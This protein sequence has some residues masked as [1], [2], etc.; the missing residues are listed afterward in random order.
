MLLCFVLCFVWRFAQHQ[1]EAAAAAGRS[2]RWGGPA[3]QRP[4]Q[5]QVLLEVAEGM[6]RF[7]SLL[8]VQQVDG[9][10]IQLLLPL[11]L[12][13]PEGCGLGVAVARTGFNMKNMN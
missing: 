11:G 12:A 10:L 5:G 2:L 3:W 8:Q 9:E 4:G 6:E 1:N 13:H 7:R